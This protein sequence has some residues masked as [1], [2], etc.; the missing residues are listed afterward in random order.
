MSGEVGEKWLQSGH[1]LEEDAQDLLA[2][3]LEEGI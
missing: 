3:E 1:V 2:D